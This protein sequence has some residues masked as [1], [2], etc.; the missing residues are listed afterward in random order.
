MVKSVYRFISG[1]F[2]TVFL[3]Y[4]VQLQPRY[5]HGLPSHARL[6]TIIDSHRS[7]YASMLESMKKYESQLAE[8]KQ[9]SE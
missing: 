3:D 5:G 1:K 9:Q 7:E 2:Q 4:K 8:I 6:N